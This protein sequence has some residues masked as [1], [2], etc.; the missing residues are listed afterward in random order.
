GVRAAYRLTHAEALAASAP[1]W[2]TAWV[3]RAEELR[4]ATYGASSRAALAE[5]AASV[6]LAAGAL[7]D[8]EPS[9]RHL[10]LTLWTATSDSIFFAG[11]IDL[12]SEAFSRAVT[13]ADA[14]GAV[15]S[16]VRARLAAA[17]ALLECGDAE[18]A[19]ALAGQAR[20]LAEGSD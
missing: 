19:A 13:V 10:G 14:C 3:E 12:R 2:L 20:L 6:A 7:G 8:S 17:R 18:R 15:A 5:L 16:R 1:R 4:S 9:T 11:A